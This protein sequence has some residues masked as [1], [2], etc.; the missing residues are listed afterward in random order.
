MGKIIS[1]SM[2]KNEADVIESFVR[3]TM[4]FVDMMLV[5]DHSSTDK[6]PEILRRLRE[7]GLPLFVR[8]IYAA[9]YVQF[10]TMNA[11]L[12]LSLIHI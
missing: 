6:T 11:L 10:E 8:R 4:S 12:R 9:G 7:E 3:H 5:A 2:V 1:I